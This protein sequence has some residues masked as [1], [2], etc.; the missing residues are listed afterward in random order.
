M[1]ALWQ[2]AYGFDKE[3]TVNST[4]RKGNKFKIVFTDVL[5]SGGIG[6]V[7]SVRSPSFITARMGVELI[8]CMKRSAYTPGCAVT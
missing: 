1:Q 2:S 4:I 7:L 3:L 5:G 6:V 8:F